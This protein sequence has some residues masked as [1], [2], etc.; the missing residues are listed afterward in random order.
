MPQAT[1]LWLLLISFKTPHP[2]LCFGYL[3]TGS[4]LCSLPT[5]TLG[6]FP[7][8]FRLCRMQPKWKFRSLSFPS[9]S[10]PYRNFSGC[11]LFLITSPK[12][13]TARRNPTF[14][15]CTVLCNTIKQNQNQ[16]QNQTKQKQKQ[17]EKKN[18]VGKIKFPWKLIYI[19]LK[20]LLI[21]SANTHKFNSHIFLFEN[22]HK[23]ITLCYRKYT[24]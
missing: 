13:Y 3:P 4:V 18:K 12:Y 17:K 10:S 11:S 16:N 7:E 22:G 1:G 6:S 8:A 23:I 19:T 24:L 15:S 9:T 14:F 21:T 5:I 2:Q 20:F